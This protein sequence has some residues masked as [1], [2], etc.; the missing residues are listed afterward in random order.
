M[1]RKRK[2][3]ISITIVLVLL[4]AGIFLEGENLLF[5]QSAE[6]NKYNKLYVNEPVPE[7]ERYQNSEIVSE[8]PELKTFKVELSYNQEINRKLPQPVTG[9]M[10]S[11]S[12]I[13]RGL[14]ISKDW[15]DLEDNAS[16]YNNEH[17]DF[18]VF[19]FLRNGDANLK[20]KVDI[21]ES[22]F[23]TLSVDIEPKVPEA[24]DLHRGTTECSDAKVSLTAESVNRDK[25]MIFGK[26]IVEE[27]STIKAPLNEF[28]GDT[29][30]VSYNQE[31]GGECLQDFTIINRFEVTHHYN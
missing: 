13:L 25:K 5:N 12:G 17:D 26:D 14:T 29:A 1:P 10:W 16:V 18:E 20:Q 21:P 2:T 4:T 24:P 7:A 6:E 15:G 8:D 30:L 27:K 19:V 11:Y 28:A 23:S 22:G 3:L 9:D 31:S